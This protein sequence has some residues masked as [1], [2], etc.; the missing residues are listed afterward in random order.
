MN[1]FSIV[2]PLYNKV[3][4]FQQCL[5]SVLCQ[6][7][8]DFEIIVINDGSTDGSE[9]ILEKFEDSRIKLISQ[10]NQGASS[11]R[12][13]GIAIAKYEWIALL[14]ADDYWYP[15]H[16]E[17]LQ[18]TK[19]KCPKASVICTNYEIVLEKTYLKQASFAVDI[20]S[21]PDYVED[22]FEASL[23]D[24]LA[25]TSALA[26]TTPIFKE[27]GGFDTQI[28]SGQDIDLIVRFGLQ[29]KM[30]FN[31]KVTMRYHRITENNL[32]DRTGLR[33]K[34]AYI[35]KHTAE[36]KRNASLKKYMDINRFSLGIQAKMKGDKALFQQ[37]RQDIDV[38]SL[39]FKQRMLFS[40]SGFML[41]KLKSI[42]RKL[43]QKNI[44]KSPFK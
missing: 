31:P 14:D 41:R 23:I 27:V 32:S 38:S 3:N 44:Y 4:Y 36:E 39:N 26:F 43:V 5:E 2:I 9:N 11:A 21:K 35:N 15:N 33:D 28:K 19:V 17:E 37:L 42:Q 25:W 29:A 18:N 1:S 8:Q 13:A 16:L 7:H 12:N 10:D 34:L 40:A 30:A 24:P 6:T 22:Y 20:Q